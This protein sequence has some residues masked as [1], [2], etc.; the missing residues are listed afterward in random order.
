[1]G[2]REYCVTKPDYLCFGLMYRYG[3]NGIWHNVNETFKSMKEVN[4]YI[5]KHQE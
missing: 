2:K 3:R 1:M 4:E 5:E